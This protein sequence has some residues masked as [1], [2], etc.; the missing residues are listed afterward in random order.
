MNKDKTAIHTATFSII[1]NI[2]LALIKYISGI[3]GNSFALIAD[4]IESLT[5]VFASILLLLGLKYAQRPADSNH[6][7]GHGKI[8]P[9]IS[10]LLAALMIFSAL[11]IAYQSIINIQTPSHTPKPWTLI[12]LGIII[13]WKELSFRFVKHRNKNIES[14]TLNAD[15]WH[16]RSDAITSLAAFIGISI[17]LVGGKGYEAADDWA[18][19]F[20]AAFIMYNSYTILRSALAEIMDENIYDELCVKINTIA[21]TV[22]GILSTEKCYIRKGGTKYFVDLHARVDGRITVA[23]G[24]KI[25]HNLKETVLKEIPAIENILIHI[26]PQN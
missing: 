23:E 17:A 19:L 6:P 24:H 21:H 8:E 10:I 22:P 26:E 18:A 16:H 9:L 14:S 7:Y 13:L 1:G 3:L 15:A 4:A 20:A 12:I 5:D 25:S 2:L 11:Y